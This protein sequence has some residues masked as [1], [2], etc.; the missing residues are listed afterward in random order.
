M[1]QDL[2]V[3]YNQLFSLNLAAVFEN[4]GFRYPAR[5]DNLNATK[6]INDRKDDGDDLTFGRIELS[7]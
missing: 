7:P 1:G 2:L 5:K 4:F 6:T 3:Q